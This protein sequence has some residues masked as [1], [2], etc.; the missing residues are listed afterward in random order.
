M[1]SLPYLDDF[2]TWTAREPDGGD[3]S[4]LQALLS[5]LLHPRTARVRFDA[6]T[7]ATLQLG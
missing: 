3:L 5:V 7:P 6:S 1:R 2:L 4:A